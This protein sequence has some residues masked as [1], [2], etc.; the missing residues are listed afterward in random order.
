[1]LLNSDIKKLVGDFYAEKN[2]FTHDL[3]NIALARTGLC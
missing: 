1:L 3:P 2:H